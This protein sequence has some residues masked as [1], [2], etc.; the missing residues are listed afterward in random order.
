MKDEIHACDTE[1][2][3]FDM[4]KGPLG[5]KYFSTF[6]KIV[7]GGKIICFSIYCGPHHNF[8]TGSRLWID[9]LS[10]D[11]IPIFKPYLEDPT[12]HKIWHNYSFDR[13]MFWNHKVNVMGFKGDTMHMT[14]LMD[15]SRLK[16]GG[17]SLESVSNDFYIRKR[18]MKE[19][20]SVAKLKRDGTPGKATFIPPTTELQTDPKYRDEWIEYS[21][22]DAESTWHV[23]QEIKQR[24]INME[25]SKEK[26]DNGNVNKLTLFDFYERYFVHFGELLTDMERNG[27]K[28]LLYYIDNS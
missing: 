5:I 4:T 24:L 17:Y 13:H 28:V 3:N 7:G 11:L 20:F 8:G 1:T 18:P 6:L 14:R 22:F 15:S 19:I 12:I 26:D 23:Y 25:W 16:N 21:A 2:T 27:V 9:N 10:I